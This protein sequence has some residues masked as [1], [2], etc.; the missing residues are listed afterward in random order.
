MTNILSVKWVALSASLVLLL[1]LNA[2]V[3]GAHNLQICKDSDAVNPVTGLFHFDVSRN[4]TAS[5]DVAAGTCGD[6]IFFLGFDPIVRRRRDF[7]KHR[8]RCCWR[9]TSLV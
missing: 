1:F 4:F 7:G 9:N 3:L 8:F 6:V 5:Q 2:G